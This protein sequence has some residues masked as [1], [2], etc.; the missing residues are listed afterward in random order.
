M[1]SPSRN[2][3]RS[4]N[5]FEC[6][7]GL[8]WTYGF[9]NVKACRGGPCAAMA[10]RSLCRESS[11][12]LNPRGWNQGTYGSVISNTALLVW[13]KTRR[14][15]ITSAKSLSSL[16]FP[17]RLSIPSSNSSES[18]PSCVRPLSLGCRV[19]RIN[20]FSLPSVACSAP[21][22]LPPTH[23]PSLLIFVLFYPECTAKP[24]VKYDDKLTTSP[25]PDA[26]PLQTSLS[27][28]TDN[29]TDNDGGHHSPSHPAPPRSFSDTPRP[30][31]RTSAQSARRRM[32]YGGRA[33]TIPSFANRDP[34]AS[35]LTIVQK[36]RSTLS[37][38]LVPEHKVGKPPGFFQELRT[39]VFGSCESTTLSFFR[40]YRAF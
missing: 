25:V 14:S 37:T 33:T 39:I 19:S 40:V 26:F 7:V 27:Q 30:G 8:C 35:S 21:P 15:H 13:I 1:P 28:H 10:M 16:P 11:K 32:T 6:C 23:S 24:T 9:C 3:P 31:R 5:G 38:L 12:Q 20:C 22:L 4:S 18:S 29:D 36:A 2:H 17:P 34:G